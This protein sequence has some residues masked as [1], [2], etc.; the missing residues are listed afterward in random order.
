[1]N[2]NAD[3]QAVCRQPHEAPN[4]CL[5][6]VFSLWLQQPSQQRT[7][8]ILV[9]ALRR[10]GEQVIADTI[11]SKYTPLNQSGMIDLF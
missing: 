10:G 1:M 4:E 11:E 5:Q 7:W 3:I 8:R 9:K 6:Q 2:Y